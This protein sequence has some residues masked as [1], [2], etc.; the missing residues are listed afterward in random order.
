MM[1]ARVVIIAQARKIFT[2]AVATSH[3]LAL[4][5]LNCRDS[6]IALIFSGTWLFCVRALN[7]WI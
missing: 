1:M 6:I 3:N 7:F 2:I 4:Y 5:R